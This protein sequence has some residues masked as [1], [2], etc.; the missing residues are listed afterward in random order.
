MEIPAS[1]SYLE[2]LVLRHPFGWNMTEAK[3]Q[4]AFSFEQIDPFYWQ[5]IAEANWKFAIYIG[6]LYIVVIH[7]LQEWMRNR[8]AYSGLKGPLILWNFAIGFLSILGFW[9]SAPGFFEVLSRPSGF[10]DTICTRNGANI[11][12]IFW[13]YVFTVLKYVE[14][15]D[16]IFILLMKKPLVFLQWYHHVVTMSVVW[17][18]GTYVQSYNF[19][20]YIFVDFLNI[21]HIPL[22]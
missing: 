17:I 22:N 16:T 21:K 2:E 12:T 5:Q 19:N 13:L 11:Q 9:R 7:V 15:G 3:D 6:A 4:G 20:F 14:L 1:I 18:T 8:P 10:Y